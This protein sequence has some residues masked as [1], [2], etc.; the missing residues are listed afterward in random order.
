MSRVTRTALVPHAALDMFELV[1]D[2]ER[3]PEYL[4]WCVSAVVHQRKGDLVRASLEV[5]RGPIR[6]TLTT[7]NRLTASSSIEMELVDGPFRHLHGLW[8]FEP[9]SSSG[10]EV[11]LD[12]DFEFSSTVLQKLMGP[13]FDEIAAS[14][15]DAFCRRA[16]QVYGEP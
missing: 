10:C 5:V 16:S 14:L 7:L 11:H 12:L 13:V 1:A 15:V 4:P 6:K 2:V 8:R 3:Y 9:L